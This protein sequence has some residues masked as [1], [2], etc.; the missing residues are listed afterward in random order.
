MKAHLSEQVGSMLRVLAQNADLIC[1]GIDG[2]V[3]PGDAKRNARIDALVTAGA[4]RSQDQSSFTLNPR[5]R[6]FVEDRLGAFQAFRQLTRI[7]PSIRHVE[8]LWLEMQTLRA[9]RAEEDAQLLE[10]EINVGLADISYDIERNLQ[11]LHAN[12]S[13]EF[14]NV[15]SLKA[16]L[17]QNAF[18]LGEVRALTKSIDKLRELADKLLHDALLTGVQSVEVAVRRNVIVH[19]LSWAQQI[20]DAQNTIA[21]RLFLAKKLQNRLGTLSRVSLWLRQRQGISS[22]REF[23]LDESFNQLL[24]RPLSFP[25][26]SHVDV[27]DVEEPVQ[28]A[29]RNIVAELKPREATVEAGSTSP[30][31]QV[32][33]VEA[34]EPIQDVIEPHEESL[35][36]LLERLST[37]GQEVSLLAWKCGDRRLDDTHAEDWLLYAGSQLMGEKIKVSHVISHAQ[38]EGLNEAFVDIVA[39][40]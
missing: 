39:T 33:A 11:V 40:S 2:A 26:L 7:D 8:R 13:S 16:K 25:R 1:E 5:L 19:L 20:N 21:K 6:S 37:P 12:I 18:F 4:L 14:G 36:M 29:L 32:M 35:L 3:L 22:E 24:L 23:D 30:A 10:T 34:E 15:S 28:K 31:A 38:A 27:K 9:E 17:R